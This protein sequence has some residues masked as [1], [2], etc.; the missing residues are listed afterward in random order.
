MK[1]DKET[2]KGFYFKF[3]VL[4][5]HNDVRVLLRKHGELLLKDGLTGVYLFP[6]AAP[7]AELSEM[8]NADE[9]KY[10]AQSLRNITNGEKFSVTE[11]ET[12]SFPSEK[13]KM[14]LLGHGLDLKITE[15]VFGEGIK[16]IKN[17]F[18]PLIIGSLLIPES[19]KQQS[20]ASQTEDLIS[21]CEKFSSRAA[22]RE[23]LSFRAAAVANMHWKPFKNG[24]EAGYRWKIG[25]LFWLPNKIK[26]TGK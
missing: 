2:V 4:V 12:A 18:T 17:I 15:K 11:A 21:L 7:I 14:I 5:P 13:E 26:S 3:L 23:K 19:D 25:K 24:D 20:R 10:T 8:F 16:K 1:N 22:P 6:W 9:L